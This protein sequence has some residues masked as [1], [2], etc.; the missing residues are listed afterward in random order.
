MKPFVVAITGASGSGKTTVARALIEALR[1]D[2]A[3]PLTA[4]LVPE[5]DYYRDSR[6]EP[7]FDAAR[8]NFDDPAARDHDLLVAHLDAWA[9]GE[10]VRRPLYDFV[11][12]GRK[13]EGVDA[14]PADVL[15][16]EGTHALCDPRVVARCGLKVFVDTPPDIAFL[17][18]LTRDIEERGRSLSGVVAQYLGTVRPSQIRWTLASATNADFSVSGGDGAEAHREDAIAAAVAAI[19]AAIH[20]RLREAA[21][22]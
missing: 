10:R 13:A 4:T 17:R 15:V 1:G 18:R 19:Q 2:A 12:H 5:D 11:T 14:D 6:N 21:G 22:G 20:A 9:R 16:L 7:G 3:R 8:H